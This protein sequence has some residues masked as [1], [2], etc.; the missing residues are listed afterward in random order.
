MRGLVFCGGWF[1]GGVHLIEKSHLLASLEG[2]LPRRCG[3]AHLGHAVLLFAIRESALTGLHKEGNCVR[4]SRAL[5]RIERACAHD[6]RGRP[7][8][9]TARR[10]RADATSM[11]GSNLAMRATYAVAA[12][13]KVIALH[14]TKYDDFSTN[15]AK[16]ADEYVAGDSGTSKALESVGPR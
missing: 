11:E 16:A 14:A 3:A 7:R 13:D 6:G 2:D 15:A 8:V 10:Q 12:M 4:R 9:V 1:C 5:A